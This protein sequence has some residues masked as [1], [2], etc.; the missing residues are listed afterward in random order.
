MKNIFW[1]IISFL[2]II[3]VTSSCEDFL[4]KAPG[5]DVTEDTI[6][7]S[8]V[9]AETFLTSIYEYG[10]HSNLPYGGLN[11]KANNNYSLTGAAADESETCANWI[12]SQKW[13]TASVSPDNTDDTRW[14]NRWIAIR[15]ISV[16]LDRIEDVPDLDPTYLEQLKGEAKFI[17]ALNYFEMF[18]R[19][20]GVPVIDHR[21]QL[22]DD[23][24]IPRGTLEEVVNFIVEDCDEA[25]AGLPSAY[26]ANLRGRVTKGA[27]LALKSR[28]LL[29]AASPQFNTGSPYLDFGTNNNL[30]CY[31]NSDLKR[32]QDAADAAEAAINWAPGA[33][34]YLIT[35][36]GVTKNY[37]Y[38]WE[39]YDNAEIILAEKSQSAKG[40]WGRPWNV[41][42]PPSLY[43]GATGQNGTT[44]TFNFVQK[45]E[46]IDGTPQTWNPNGGSDLQARM[47]ELDPR[48]HQT[49]AY[50]MSFWNVD[51]PQV[52]IYQGGRDVNTCYGGFWL[53]KHY[54]EAIVQSHRE[55]IPNSTLFA[56]A[57]VYLNYAE[58]LNEAQGP[59]PAAYEAVNTIRRRSGMPDLPSGLSQSQFRERVRNERA[60]ELAFDDSRFWDIRRWL[61]AGEVANGPMYGIK[62][63]RITGS[64]EFRYEPYVFETRTWV[65]KMYLHPFGTT[66]INK[67][68]LVQNPGY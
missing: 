22:T 42:C 23:L 33:G 66:E 59:V 3:V 30:I 50:N 16:F 24:K 11:A 40:S 48:F 44:P 49:I 18:K 28:T 29:Y 53:H 32:W 61:I 63:Y 62:I 37:K 26:P 25:I 15:K 47:A 14:S 31:G 4:E 38:A 68:Y 7:S 2:V 41:I 43:P 13:N 1:A 64:S 65:P 19:Y 9:Q 36:Q 58:A 6:F 12:E 45:Y 27:A 56:L 46:K 5:I 67:G 55:Y 21:I 60:I 10:I 20:G 51:F 17:R 8:R 54:P 52:Q 39:V 35:D 34:C 57:E